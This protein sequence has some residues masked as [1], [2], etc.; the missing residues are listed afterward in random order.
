MSGEFTFNGRSSAEFGLLVNNV[1]NFG[2]PSRV[3]EKVQVPYRNGDLLIDT[4]AYTNYTVTYNVSLIYNA[5]DTTRELAAWLLSPQGYCELTDSYNIGETRYAAFYGDLNYEMEH[6]NRSGSAN[7]SFDCKPQRY[8]AS[9]TTQ[10][11][12]PASGSVTLTNPT[13]FG[14]RPLIEMEDGA[15]PVTG[16]ITIG[17]LDRYFNIDFVNPFVAGTHFIDCEKM[18]CYVEVIELGVKYLRN[19]NNKFEFP[20]GFP[21]IES[22]TVTIDNT[23]NR[24][25][26]VTPRWWR[27]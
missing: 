4:G 26:K 1:S 5:V 17:N 6:L 3:V 25:I 15:T 2:A 27:L 23:S 16:R 21:V 13:M 14:A 8:L 20:D 7:I 18:Q 22:G 10:T 24:D 19:A 11:S 12:I 9:G